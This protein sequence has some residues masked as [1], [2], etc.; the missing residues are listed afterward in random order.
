MTR[1]VFLGLT[2]LAV[3]L[4][5]FFLWAA[6]HGGTYGH[7]GYYSSHY[8]HSGWIVTGWRMGTGDYDDY[9]GNGANY[10]GGGPGAGGK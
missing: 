4:P 6:P 8:H 7:G 3:L 2:V 1:I 5:Y 10:R 9:R